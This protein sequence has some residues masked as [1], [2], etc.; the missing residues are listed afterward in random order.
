[1]MRICMSPK[2]K[3]TRA[4]NQ[5]QVTQPQLKKLIQG[6]KNTAIKILL[7]KSNVYV[8]LNGNWSLLCKE[9]EV[10]SKL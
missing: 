4:S 7:Q 10:E 9:S 3:S 1:M 8:L 5:E 6:K 2:T